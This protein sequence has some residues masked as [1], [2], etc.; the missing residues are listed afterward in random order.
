MTQRLFFRLTCSCN[1]LTLARPI[2]KLCNGQLPGGKKTLLTITQAGLLFKFST[3]AD[4]AYFV[5][6]ILRKRQG[7]GSKE[8]GISRRIVLLFD[9]HG[10]I[11]ETKGGVF[12]GSENSKCLGPCGA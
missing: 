7:Y 1:A 12:D 11:I 10:G 3:T 4:L 5:Y 8:A 2:K 6:R 9:I